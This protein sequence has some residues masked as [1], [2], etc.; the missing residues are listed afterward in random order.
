MRLCLPTI[1]RMCVIQL[2]GLSAGQGGGS[3]A[4]NTGKYN[5]LYCER[6]SIG[7]SDPAFLLDPSQPV[8]SMTG[9]SKRLE[10]SKAINDH[11]RLGMQYGI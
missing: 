2:K 3:S 8:D 6:N 1:V 11:S 4:N 7:N 9:G 5:L 10:F